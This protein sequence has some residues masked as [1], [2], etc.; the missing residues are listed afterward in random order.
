M[1]KASLY[2]SVVLALLVVFLPSPI[3]ASDNATV[4]LTV[5]VLRKSYSSGGYGVSF[6][7]WLPDDADSDKITDE[8]PLIPDEPDADIPIEEDA[9]EL[10]PWIPGQTQPATS[11]PW[12][13]LVNWVQVMIV[14]IALLVGIAGY[15]GWREWRRRRLLR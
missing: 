3:V 6:S 1:R 11:V 9:T 15:V 12:Y 10:E 8:I 5:E 13:S 4:N 2:F 7:W 14:L